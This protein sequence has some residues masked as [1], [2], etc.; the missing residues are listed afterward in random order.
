MR[1]F[2]SAVL[3]VTLLVVAVPA[4]AH[5]SFNTIYDISRTV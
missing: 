5:H 4:R 2:L 3:A 1:L